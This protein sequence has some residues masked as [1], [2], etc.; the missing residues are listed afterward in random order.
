MTMIQVPTDRCAAE[1]PRS[2]I[3]FAFVLVSTVAARAE[4]N[5][6]PSHIFSPWL[7]GDSPTHN[8]AYY[9]RLKLGG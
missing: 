9:G 6:T 1:R 4:D 2:A 7:V 8:P 3:L 5:Q